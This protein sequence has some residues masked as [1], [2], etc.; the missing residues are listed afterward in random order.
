MFAGRE[1]TKIQVLDDLAPTDTGE[2]TGA[3]MY[4]KLSV[5]HDRACTT[6]HTHYG[7]IHRNY[8]VMP[9]L[10]RGADPFVPGMSLQDIRKL[11]GMATGATQ[12]AELW[13]RTG[14]A[15]S[16]LCEAADRDGGQ[17]VVVVAHATVVASLLCRVL[18]LDQTKTALFR[19][20]TAGLVA[21]A[22]GE[23]LNINAV[24]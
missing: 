2:F 23:S 16:T 12:L 14:R 6:P 22:A 15:W 19:I 5:S 10:L 3:F 18:G 20:E 21:A 7:V 13:Q 1:M 17:T 9:L 4:S 11:G 24:I 8:C